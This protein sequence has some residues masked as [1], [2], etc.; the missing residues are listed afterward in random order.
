MKNM[1]IIGEASS[2]FYYNGQAR[3]INETH[4]MYAD[5][6]AAAKV[7]DFDRVDEL[8]DMEASVT[9]AIPD[10][11]EVYIEDGVV[12]FMGEQLHGHGVDRILEFMTLGIDFEPMRLFL[13]R[14]MHN[15]SSRAVRELF[16]FL[17][18][19]E[20]PLTSDGCFLAYKKI[21]SDYT[22]IYTG[23]FDNS[24]GAVATM[25]RKDVDSDKDRTCSSGLHFCSYEYLPAFGWGTGNRVVVVKIDPADVVSIPSDY[26]NAKGRCCRYEVVEEITQEWA[27]KEGF[28]SPV[29]DG[30]TVEFQASWTLSVELHPEFEFNVM[31]VNVD[32]ARR[33][34]WE[35]VARQFD[36][37]NSEFMTKA[38]FMDD[39]YDEA[40]SNGQSLDDDTAE[41]LWMDYVTS[42]VM[43]DVKAVESEVEEPTDNEIES[44]LEDDMVD[45]EWVPDT[46]AEPDTEVLPEPTKRREWWKD[47]PRNEKGHFIKREDA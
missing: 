6:L 34:V 1:L 5:V 16:G 35:N 31:A 30:A 40:E 11:A 43:V 8:M 2:T 14:L 20:L 46:T 26:N 21:R 28:D 22:D 25:E 29:S 12:M 17:E 24:V 38:E 9:K 7:R 15:P 47:Q 32:D 44:Q 36:G 23:T 45:L 4:P 42:C 13:T 19:S 39:V 33:Q 18:A 41:E 10:S 3:V 27:V 37:H